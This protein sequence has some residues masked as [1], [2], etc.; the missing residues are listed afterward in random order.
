MVECLES[1]GQSWNTK[2]LEENCALL[3]R[4]YGAIVM[5]Y[6]HMMPTQLWSTLAQQ[7]TADVDWEAVLPNLFSDTVTSE[8]EDLGSQ[9]V[10]VGV[11]R[12]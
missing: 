4:C 8:D 7:G 2:A 6:F 1:S 9:I 11:D 5:C 3:W 12:E 10:K